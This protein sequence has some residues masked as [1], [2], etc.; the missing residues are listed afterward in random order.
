[1]QRTAALVLTGGT[2]AAVAALLVAPSGWAQTWPA[3][4]VRIIV[5]FAA[6]GGT[7]IQ[8]RLLAKQFYAGTQQTFVVD[9]RASANGLI[10]VEAV[11]RAAPDGYTLLF[12][13]A[14]LSVNTTLYAK[15]L[16]FDPV[17]DLAPVSWISS[18]PLVLVVHPSVPAKSVKELVALTRRPNS[19]I[20]AASNSSGSTSH[21]A[22]EMLKQMTGAQLVHIPYKGSG[23]AMTAVVGG[24]VD[25]VFSTSLA[26]QPHIKSGRVRALAVTTAKPSSAFP[27]LPTMTSIYPGFEADN[28]YGLFF[29]AGT[30]K[31]VIARMNAEA[32]KALKAPD[33]LEFMARE[34]AD[35]VG[36]TPEELGA[37]FRR[38]VE[39]YAKVIREANIQSE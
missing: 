30:P 16:T 29:P 38:E 2:I 39:R 23:P 7:D 27:D 37:Q 26:A 17:K 18:L 36:S 12:V 31:E 4:P 24:E 28:W 33:L 25:F 19:K 32:L 35:P 5:P 9:N 11:A 8:A 14:S 15:R 21:L 13:S 10:G 6:G 1:M 20:N 34:G 3:K 22:L